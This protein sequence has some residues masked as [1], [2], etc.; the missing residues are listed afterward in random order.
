[1]SL[2]HS[3]PHVD[4][5]R[6]RRFLRYVFIERPRERQALLLG[7]LRLRGFEARVAW[8]LIGGGAVLVGMLYLASPR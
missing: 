2:T 7:L 6:V 4:T 5:C 3:R 8:G 1:M